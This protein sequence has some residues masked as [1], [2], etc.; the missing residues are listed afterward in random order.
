MED[1]D[2]IFARDLQGERCGGQLNPQND[3]VQAWCFDGSVFNISTT[4][5]C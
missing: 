4:T 2:I 5:L 1:N 3:V